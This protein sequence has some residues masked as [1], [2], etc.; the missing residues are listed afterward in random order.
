[1]MAKPPG[2]PASVVTAGGNGGYSLEQLWQ[3]TTRPSHLV[4]RSAG[5]ELIRAPAGY[6]QILKL[7]AESQREPGEP[8]EEGSA[9]LGQSHSNVPDR[10]SAAAE[11]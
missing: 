3:T 8:G 11:K 6:G 4:G 2:D 7:L 10:M 5:T 9:T 1:M